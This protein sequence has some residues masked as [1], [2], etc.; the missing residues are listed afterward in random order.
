VH[1][2]VRALYA[3]I[4]IWSCFYWKWWA[5]IDWNSL[6]S[7]LAVLW[8]FYVLVTLVANFQV[9]SRWMLLMPFYSLVQ[10][11]LLPLLGAVCYFGLVR[12]RG[13][14][15]RYRFGYARREPPA[16]VPPPRPA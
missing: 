7:T 1:R 3:T 13:S 10:G 8:L 9:R 15:G 2:P 5:M 4:G 14:F 16:A 6:P 11:M 12:K